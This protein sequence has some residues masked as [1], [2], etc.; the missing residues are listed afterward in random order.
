LKGSV[1]VGTDEKE[2]RQF[3]TLVFSAESEQNG[4][5]LEALE[6]GTELTLVCPYPYLIILIIAIVDVLGI[7]SQENL[8]IKPSTSMVRSS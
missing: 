8:S 7:R 6:D 5:S 4:V 1:K 2:H 3:H